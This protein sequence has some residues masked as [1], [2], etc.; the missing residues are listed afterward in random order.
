VSQIGWIARRSI[1]RTLRQ[2]ALIVPT[3][4]FPLFLMAVNATGL[5]AATK[6]PGFPTDN[7]LSFTMS[8]CFMQG[9]LFAAITAGTTVAG[10]IE[11][12]FFNRLSLTP[13]S[14]TSILTGQLAGSVAIA[15][16]GITTFIG[17]GLIA[18]V[19]VHAGV[20]GVLVLV[21]LAL[22]VSVAFAGLGTAIG[23]RTGRAE[24][25]QGVFPLLF[26]SLFLSSSS[27]PRNLIET[28]WF[29]QIATYN[30]VSYLIEGMRS[31]IITGWDGE[32]LAQGFGWAL[33]I[34]VV[35]WTLAARAMKTRMAR[36]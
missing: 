4:V 11:S 6:L 22:L 1:R 15:L 20:A 23:V 9:A 18:G 25:V 33:V 7:Y 17:V 35:A 36:T 12:G 26:V 31:L 13:L 5:S 10:D 8:V 21:A 2:P 29:R 24:A 34:G 28:D 14:G 19:S 16:I 3:I 32:A 27:L 30:P